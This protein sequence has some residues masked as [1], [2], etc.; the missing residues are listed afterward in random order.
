MAEINNILIENEIKEQKTDEIVHMIDELI[1]IKDND[2]IDDT[3]NIENKMIDEDETENKNINKDETDNKNINLDETDNKNINV[4]DEF[5][6]YD[7][8]P[9]LEGN[10]NI[11]NLRNYNK[12]DLTN[13]FR[14]I[15]P[16]NEKHMYTILMIYKFIFTDL[17]IYRDIN[18][19][20]T[21]K[22]NDISKLDFA[23]LFKENNKKLKRNF[24]AL[25]IY[26]KKV[27]AYKK[28]LD[29]CFSYF[30]WLIDNSAPF[31]QY[32]TN[33]IK[34]NIII[35]TIEL[36]MYNSTI[37][38][39]LMSSIINF[40]TNTYKNEFIKQIVK[41]NSVYLSMEFH[42]DDLI[43]KIKNELGEIT[44]NLINDLFS[45]ESEIQKIK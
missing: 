31:I 7:N 17:T 4:N 20:N 37:I 8:S 45:L 27:I 18:E 32:T 35:N 25:K 28:L 11:S 38:K 24:N 19:I 22:I 23:L 15:I 2:N 33:Q 43:L 41:F 21:D 9:Y 6:S 29:L 34:Y 3:G 1:E 36:N 44:K 14:K 39:K 10:I 30:I 16:D 40:F 42:I 12:T 13:D 26:Q 5:D